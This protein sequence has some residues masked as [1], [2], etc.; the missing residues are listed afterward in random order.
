MNEFNPAEILES[1]QPN[2][3]RFS[4]KHLIW[5][6]IVGLAVYGLATSIYTVP[7][8]SRAVV[9][10]FGESIEQKE[11]GLHFKLPFGIDRQYPVPVKRI[12]KE[13][14][15]F[16]TLQASV[17]TQYD[18]RDYPG[19]SLMLTGDLN[20]A[21]VEWV[22]QYKIS[23]PESYLFS[24]RNPEQALRDLAESVMRLVVGDRTVTEVLTIGRSE[25]VHWP[26]G[27]SARG[28]IRHQ[29]AQLT[30]IMATCLE[31]SS[32][33]YPTEHKGHKI[34][35]LQGDSLV[36][37]F[38]NQDNGKEVLYWE[39]EG[40]RAVRKGRW[41][42]VSKYP[43][44]WELYDIGK[45][46]TELNDLSPQ[47]PK[48]VTELLSLYDAWADLCSVESWDDITTSRKSR[49]AN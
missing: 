3:N 45:D 43:G 48:V 17:T 25:I 36:P 30:D 6:I 28:E 16:R 44:N 19:E 2:F 15:G 9:L 38:D 13:E 49:R 12:F 37:I 21:D 42:L 47:Y 29:P 7:E 8:D 46:R 1:L 31:V 18:T 33:K 11:S 24:I 26:A 41:K 32:A 20:I 10:R 34:Q 40:N 35:P 5:V 23:N 4:G 14:F 39:H 22:V 27:I